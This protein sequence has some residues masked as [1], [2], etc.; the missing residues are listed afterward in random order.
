[1]AATTAGLCRRT[2]LVALYLNVSALRLL[3]QSH[4]GDV[5]EVS[6]EESGLGLSPTCS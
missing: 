4:Q 3:T 5:V 2:N 1:M 6:F